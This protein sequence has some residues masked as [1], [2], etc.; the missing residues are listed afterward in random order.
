M[1]I[2]IRRL[3][4]GMAADFFRYFE[5]LAF[6]PG[7]P[8]ANCY[9]LESHLVD[10]DRYMEVFDRRMAARELI[11]SGR[12]T[13]YLLYDGGTPVGWCNAG[14]KC[15][16]QPIME[17]EKYF[18]TDCRPG[19]IKI[20][21]CIDIAEGCQGRGLAALAMERFL[22]DAKA[23]GCQYA[24]GYPFAKPDYPWQYRGPVRLYE[25]LGFTRFDER[26]GFYIYRKKL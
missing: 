25:K 26:P 3:E 15:G 16:Y 20:M 24:E 4:P 5:E 6:P 1:D 7:D 17:N 22:A 19:Q 9:C 18:T 23:E 10:E 21:Y 12:M 8:R 11:C 13:G 14:D 2:T